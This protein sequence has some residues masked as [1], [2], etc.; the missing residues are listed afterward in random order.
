MLLIGGCM[1]L[2]FLIHLLSSFKVDRQ[3]IQAARQA[4]MLKLTELEARI[5]IAH[6]STDKFSGDV[7]AWKALTDAQSE[8]ITLLKAD[9]KDSE[10]EHAD[11]LTAT[12]MLNNMNM[13]HM[14][15]R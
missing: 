4:R 7:T 11:N 1:V 13:R 12:M 5:T 9:V 2:F 14:E 3:R 8:Y 10:A 15:R 6:E